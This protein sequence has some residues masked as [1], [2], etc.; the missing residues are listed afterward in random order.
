MYEKAFIKIVP[1]K[2]VRC[3]ILNVNTQN[4]LVKRGLIPVDS[5]MIGIK[6][7]VNKISQSSSAY[8]PKRAM[9]RRG[10]ST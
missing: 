6:Y 9:F 1:E 10:K 3:D 2:F 4:K 5:Q 8:N 7:W